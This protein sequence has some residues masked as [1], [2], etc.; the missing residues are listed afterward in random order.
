VSIGKKY[1]QAI[2]KETGEEKLTATA[3]IKTDRIFLYG[4]CN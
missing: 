1:L 2:H 3:K 4:T